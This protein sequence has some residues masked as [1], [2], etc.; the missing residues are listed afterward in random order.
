MRREDISIRV[1]LL[2]E[3]HQQ[4]DDKI[5]EMNSRH[6]LSSTDYSLLRELKVMRLRCRDAIEEIERESG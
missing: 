1:T 5:D 3:R 6:C 2:R 4:L